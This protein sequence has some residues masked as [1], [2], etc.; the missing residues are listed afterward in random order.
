MATYATL[1]TVTRDTIRQLGLVGI[2][3][4]NIKITKLPKREE[5]LDTLPC[6]LIIPH[7]RPE[8]ITRMSMEGDAS[9]AYRVSIVV[10]SAGNRDYTDTSLATDLTW[11]DTIIK[12]FER[13]PLNTLGLPTSIWEM[14][15]D[16]DVFMDRSIMNRMYDYQALSV[17]Y[18]SMERKDGT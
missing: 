6:V 18:H 1:L 8:S 17:I 12:V 4:A 11:R 16:T 3:Q 10:V 2:A 13:L 7:D 9:Y 14:R 5:N 15:V